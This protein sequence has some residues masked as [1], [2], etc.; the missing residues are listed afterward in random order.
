MVRD[1]SRRIAEDAARKV[2]ARAAQIDATDRIAVSIG[3]LRTA[4]MEA[5]ISASA[6]ERALDEE[7]N[8]PPETAAPHPRR[9]TTRLV[10]AVIAALFFLFGVYAVERTVVPAPPPVVEEPAAPGPLPR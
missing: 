3:E 4:A 6:L 5:G 2:L 1:E 8:S 10:F 7:V 9:R